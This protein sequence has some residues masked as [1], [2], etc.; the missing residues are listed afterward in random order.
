MEQPSA[1]KVN[2]RVNVPLIEKQSHISVRSENRTDRGNDN[3]SSPHCHVIR[4]GIQRGDDQEKSGNQE[5]VVE[6]LPGRR[7]YPGTEPRQYF[8]AAQTNQN[9]NARGK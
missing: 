1:A 7:E 2:D 6:S 5:Q 4:S 8:N 9:Q 3:N